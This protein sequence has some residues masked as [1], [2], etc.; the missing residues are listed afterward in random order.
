MTLNPG[1]K[2]GPYEILSPLGAGGMGEVYRARD[3]RLGREV[4]IKVLPQHL[5]SN[6]EVRARF[7]REAKT[8]SALNHPYICVLYD[9]GREGSTDYLVMELIEGETL[10]HRIAK[11]PLPV[12]EV[13]KIGAQI[14]DALDR[15]H[16]AAVVHR[17]LKPGNVMLTRSGA[18]LMDF[19]LARATGLAGPRSGSNAADMTHSPTVAQPL[20]AEGSIVGTFQYMAP[21]QLEGREVDARTDI[22]SLGCVLYEMA[23][24]KRAF[25][26]E[27]QASLISSIMR[28]EP[29]AMSDLAPLSPPSLERLVKQCM[30][31]DPMDRWQT[32]GD[33]RRELEWIANSSTQHTAPAVVRRRNL[34]RS[35]MGWIAAAV[36]ASAAAAYILGPGAHK[37]APAPLMRFS[38]DNPPGNVL[39]TPAEM[40]LSPDGTML[41]FV[42]YD[43][44]GTAHV[45]VRPLASAQSRMLVGTDKASLPFW[46][47][48]SRAL[49]FF[50]SGKLFKMA[51]DASA[52]TALCDAPDARGGS[53]SPTGVI[54]FAPN[55]QGPI[56]RVSANGGD[57]TPITTLD[58]QRGERGH[59]Y[60]QFLPDGK[61]FLYVAVGSGDKVSTYCASVDGGKASEVCQAGSDAVWAAPGYL[62]FLDS[63]VNSLQRRL[64]A[65][66]VDASLH[67]VGDRELIVDP[68]SS[69]NFGYGNITADAHGTLVVEH[70]SAAHARLEWRNGLDGTRLGTAVDD[71]SFDAATLSPDGTRLAYAGVDPTDVFVLDLQTHVTTRLT[72]E[73]RRITSIVWSPDQKRIAFSRLSQAR[74]WQVY[75]KNTDG[76]GVDSLLFRGPAMFNDATDWSRDGHW[77]VAQCADSSGERDMWKIDVASGKASVY[78]RTPGQEQ[79]G[80]LSPDGKWLAY[81]V[82]EGDQPSVY[83]QSFPSPG[84]KY[85]LT[86]RD[87]A[88]TVWN[89][90]GTALFIGCRDGSVYQVPV[91]TEGGFRQGTIRRLYRLGPTDQFIGIT[92]DKFLIGVAKDLSALSR[93]EIVLNWTQLLQHQ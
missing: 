32:A 4:A 44:S 39:A 11:G 82:N 24:A 81:V 88:G 56:A 17:D 20:T 40:A 73:N 25:E 29:R 89:E 30:A 63:G 71:I 59:R 43:S 79:Q 18:K 62:L 55:N 9:V 33:V 15:A 36:I 66:R 50:A 91:V 74:G 78:Q 54:V 65:Q 46:S 83:V 28:D 75:T 87:A 22:W 16:R 61:R 67:A 57:A 93:L 64:L 34:R 6:S 31:K 70:W 68:V 76:S 14:A 1:T 69:E 60:P 72:F 85:Q 26:G 58:A 86:V 27:T 3:T 19:G 7:E 10:A 42:A 53:W 12:P 51:I 21:E 13:L 77:L 52:P 92:K 90:N 48:D 8:V 49:G 41:A 23:T 5:S 37:P 35:A 2:L 47:P 80:S 45:F 84:V 38:I